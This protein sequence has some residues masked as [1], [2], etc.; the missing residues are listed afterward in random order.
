MKKNLFC[1][2]FLSMGVVFAQSS[3]TLELFEKAKDA[4]E[5]NDLTLSKNILTEINKRINSE[6][7]SN[8][9]DII[10][11]EDFVN[12]F[13]NNE[14]T[15]AKKYGGK[16]IKLKG[17]AK[18]IERLCDPRIG[19][20]PGWVSAIELADKPFTA[21]FNTA[22]CYCT[23]DMKDVC[24]EL[25]RGASVIIEGTFYENRYQFARIVDCNVFVLS[26]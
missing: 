4:Y 21:T 1:L 15:A 13:K 11:I 20:G 8:I 17:Y 6:L 12:E 24:A 9:D 18:T 7:A 22:T 10:E 23:L 5:S 25:Q 26:E 19:D 2:I 3:S 14:L 16:K